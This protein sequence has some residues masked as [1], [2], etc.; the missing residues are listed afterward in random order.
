MVA[1]VAR[2]LEATGYL[3]LRA[4]RTRLSS[5]W[6]SADLVAINHGRC[7]FVVVGRVEHRLGQR[8][9]HFAENVRRAGGELIVVV[10]PADLERLG[11]TMGQNNG[12]ARD[13]LTF[14]DGAA[15]AAEALTREF[16]PPATEVAVGA[17]PPAP[18]E[19]PGMAERL[20]GLLR[21]TRRADRDRPSSA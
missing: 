5:K 1:A 2:R 4:G 21:G 7:L 19:L 11:A 6:G 12:R 15:N 14:R 20:R 18:A 9:Q 3:V 10:G 17:V 13:A 8:Q 16:S